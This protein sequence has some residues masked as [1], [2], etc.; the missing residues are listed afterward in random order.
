M[1]WSNFRARGANSLKRAEVDVLR[2]ISEQGCKRRAVAASHMQ[3]VA[4]E[5]AP[6]WGTAL[7]LQAVIFTTDHPY[8]M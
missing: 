4:T 3:A 7:A 1:P 6:C 5:Q 2:H 8:F